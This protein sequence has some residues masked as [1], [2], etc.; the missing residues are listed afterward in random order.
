MK[1]LWMACL[2]LV[3]VLLGNGHPQE[4]MKSGD[5]E[6]KTVDQLWDE[7]DQAKAEGLPKSAIAK[8]EQILKMTSGPNLEKEWLLALTEKIFLEGTIEG[9]KPEERIKRLKVELAK[10]GPRTKPLLQAVLA[11]WFKHYFDKNRWRFI[12]RSSTEGM[13]EDDITT[14]DLRKIFAEIDK[15]YFDILQQKDFLKT[16]PTKAFIG[17]LEKGS[18][19]VDLRPTLYDFLA[20]EALGFYCWPEQAGAAPE[21]AFAL[22]A[23][24]AALAPLPEFLNYEPET[25]DKKSAGYKAVKLFQELLRF[26]QQRGVSDA[27]VSLDLDRLRYVYNTAVGENK[28]ARY[29]ERLKEIQ[30]K[31]KQTAISNFADYYLAKTYQETG[32]LQ[33]AF[34]IAQAGAIKFPASL[35]AKSCRALL[36]EITAKSVSLQAENTYLP[37]GGKIGFGYKNFRKIYFR[38]VKDDWARF[39]KKKWGH[40]LRLDNQEIEKLLKNKAVASW[41]MD[42]SATVDYKEKRLETNFPALA[43]GFYRVFASWQPDFVNS[44]QVAY[45]GVWV[46]SITLVTRVSGNEISGLVVESLSGEPVAAAEVSLIR[47]QDSNFSFAAKKITDENGSFSFPKEN[48]YYEQYLH[49][50]YG[51]D[52]LLSKNSLNAYRRGDE[53]P[54]RKIVFFT[55][56]SL[57][58]P[59]QTIYFKGIAVHVD[60]V[61]NDYRLL[62][63]QEIVVRF[64]DNNGQEVARQTLKSN[65]F[66][67]ISGT[68]MAPSDRLTGQMSLDTNNF[69]GRA[70]FRVEEYKRPKFEVSLEKPTSGV[71]LGAQVTI[72]GKALNYNGAAVDNARVRYRVQRQARFPYWYYWY[73]MNTNQSSQEI[74]HGTL[75]TGSDGGFAITFQAQ[76]D[77]TIAEKDDPTFIFSINAEVLDSAGETRTASTGIVVGYYSALALRLDAPPMIETQQGF[78]LQV[79]GFTLDGLPLASS[80][81]VQIYRLRQPDQPVSESFWENV[82]SPVFGSDWRQWPVAGQQWQGKFNASEKSAQS[83]PLKLIAGFYRVEARARDSFGREVKALLPLQVL[84]ER[85]LKHFPL[86]LTNLVKVSNEIVEV[87][88]TLELFWGTGFESGSCFI[89]VECQNRIITSFW[90]EPGTTQQLF[91][92]P[93]KEAFRGG[94]TIH[95]SQVSHN[96]AY[97]QRIAIAVPWDNKELLVETKTFRSKLQPGEKETI[98]IRVKAK[99]GDLKMAEL[100]AAMYDFSLDQFYAHYWHPFNFFRY[101]Q[102]QRQC[103]GSNNV[104]H[105]N[106]WREYWNKHEAVPRLTHIHF[107]ETIIRNLF[108]YE[109]GGRM[110]RGNGK[111]K[112]EQKLAMM[113]EAAI[114]SEAG[115]I[116]EQSAVS[117]LDATIDTKKNMASVNILGDKT[118]T[119]S[120]KTGDTSTQGVQVRRNLQETAFFYP[121]LQMAEDGTVTISFSM[122]ES[123]TKWKFLGFAHSKELQSGVCTNYTVTQKELM[124]TPNPPRFLREGDVLQF[125]AKVT[126]LSEKEQVGVVELNFADLLSDQRQNQ[127]LQLQ[128]VKQNFKLA[129]KSSQ[130]FS[131]ELRVPRNLG[132]LSYT[133]IAKSAVYSDGEAGALPVL[134]SRIMLTES[135]PLNVRGPQQKKFIFER[136]QQL[137]KSDTLEALK[138]TVQMSSNP[139]WYAIQALPYLIEFTYECSEQVF[140]RYYGNLLAGFIANSDPKIRQIFDQWRGTAALKSNLDKNQDLKSALLQET[141]WVLQAKSESQAKEN[142]GLLFETNTLRSNIASALAKLKQQQL[143]NGAFPWFPGGRPDPFITLYIM[144]GCGRLQ[145]LGVSCDQQLGSSTLN[146]LDNWIRQVYNQIKDKNLNHLS[147]TIAFYLYGRSFFLKENPISSSSKTAVNYFL[148]QG[149]TYWLSL[150]SRLSQAQLA[151]ALQRFGNVETAKKIVASIKERSVVNEEMGRFWRE[152][153]LSYFW[154]RAPIESQAMMVEAFAEI[155][156]DEKAVEDCRVWLLKQKETQHWRSTKATA[157]AIYALILRGGNWLSANKTVQVW[158]G[159]LEVKPEKVEAGTGYYEKVYTPEKISAAMAQVTVK[160]DEPGI[161]WGGVHFQYFEDM[162]KVTSHQTNLKLEKKLFVKRD[163][164]SG[165]VIEPVKGPL[166]PG[167]LLVNRIVLRVDRD[168]E[169]V[170]LKDLRGSGLEPVDVLSSYR[171]QDGLAYYQSTRDTASHFFIDYLPKGTYVFEYQLRVQLKGRY[172][173]GVAEIQCMYA[174]YFNAHSESL[175][176][177]VK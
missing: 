144:T 152:D 29:R 44:S 74:A 135:L 131:W 58:R 64:R 79:Q 177:E 148:E 127:A 33:K 112:D 145:H 73:H 23:D 28:L 176:L 158:L 66:G 162:S 48:H 42:L 61:K 81:T 24:S 166:Q 92:L 156:R 39:M 150:N 43:P 160:K 138:L 132:P 67:S 155:T 62:P 91:K 101:E 89:E 170:H 94:L 10:A 30:G 102:S 71:K 143:S 34:A 122:P 47:R 82:P 83:L 14:W 99:K 121:H 147:N 7:V 93:I 63:G 173:T 151:L 171:Y 17:F 86:K 27:L 174:P 105:F 65:D 18:L 153:E 159:D 111:F 146:Y 117:D 22:E 37:S 35:A 72:K 116:K 165:P 113:P 123:L 129:A 98:K 78:K 13:K 118:K 124:V 36:S 69:N 100:A 76:P 38:I 120:E 88:K 80:G 70:Y 8:L 139:A 1:N 167:D 115:T 6:L 90:S 57:Y 31:P 110:R 128:N 11:S 3:V 60:S 26:Q 137:G 161:A 103:W 68:F 53:S 163:S 12:Q 130:G 96:R 133:V 15:L 125:T 5:K 104:I 4:N 87:G 109:F 164:K 41:K 154:Y 52:E 51:A 77:K 136:L 56:R 54:S 134:S 119:D 169:Y 168:M 106:N 40:P 21:D 149:K 50:R 75:T 45:A 126:N 16:I 175:V 107:P 97:L 55:D 142:V 141:P 85:K 46:S 59:G 172:Q 20:H 95:C 32:E 9:N 2:L 19:P 157:D 84:P 140:N 108:Y 49:V 25:T 114:E